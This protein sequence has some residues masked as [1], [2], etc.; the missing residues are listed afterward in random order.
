MKDAEIVTILGRD[1]V[2]MHVIP[3]HSHQCCVALKGHLKNWE[4]TPFS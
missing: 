2:M 3:L 1:V 4:G